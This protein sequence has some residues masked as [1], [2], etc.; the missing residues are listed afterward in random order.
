MGG[1]GVATKDFVSTHTHGMM[2]LVLN[3]GPFII[4]LPKQSEFTFE[5]ISQL[6][7]EGRD[8]VKK[9]TGDS[10]HLTCLATG[11]YVPQPG[12]RTVK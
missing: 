4:I 9:S 6:Q 1:R 3:H 7:F 8:R 10:L 11:S 12:G 5:T 2:Y